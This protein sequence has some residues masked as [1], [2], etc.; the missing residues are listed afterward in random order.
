M[1]LVVFSLQLFVFELLTLGFSNLGSLFLARIVNH[2][3]WS[4]YLQ[5]EHST[6]VDDYGSV[7][8]G[9]VKSVKQVQKPTSITPVSWF[10]VGEPIT[11]LFGDALARH[12]VCIII[13][14]LEPAPGLFD[15]AFARN[16]FRVYILV[17]LLVSTP[18]LFPCPAVFGCGC[19]WLAC[20]TTISARPPP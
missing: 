15:S 3:K 13:I 7:L 6:V 8:L 20:S 12:V 19:N 4:R 2:S 5:L 17:A 1:S 16:Q 18:S 10:R 11:L 14:A 9:G